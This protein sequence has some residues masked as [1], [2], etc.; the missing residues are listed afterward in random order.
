[1]LICDHTSVGILVW[2]GADLL[3]I[4]R[5]NAPI[6][7]APPAGHVDEQGSFERAAKLELY[8]EVGLVADQ[9]ELLAE[10]RKDNRCRRENG[11]WHYWKIYEANVSGQVRLSPRETRGFIW[12]APRVVQELVER[13]E[14]YSR[15]LIDEMEWIT[16][17]GL[18]PIWVEW[19]KE[20]NII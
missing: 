16:K 18:E 5:R 14:R 11:T 13:T 19:F 17:P 1:M 6:G 8:Q 20:L 9:L 10:G 12:A 7:Y 2:R 15:N 3:L 4:E